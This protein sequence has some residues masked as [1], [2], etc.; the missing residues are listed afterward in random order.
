VRH[1]GNVYPVNGSRDIIAQVKPVMTVTKDVINKQSRMIHRNVSRTGVSHIP[2]RSG[3]RHARVEWNHVGHGGCRRA[4]P[5]GRCRDWVCEH[6]K[7]TSL[8]FQ[9]QICTSISYQL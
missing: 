4:P 6:Q 5:L 1:H 2:G 3:A 8:H 9:A 7:F